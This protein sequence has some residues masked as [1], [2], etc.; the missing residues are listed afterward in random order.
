M[1][2]LTDIKIVLREKFPK[3]AARL[4]YNNA[5][6]EESDII[7]AT[8]WTT[9]Y[10]IAS[11]KTKARRY[12]YV[13]DFEP[14]FQPPGTNSVLADNTYKLGFRGITLGKWLTQK[15]SKEYNMKCDYFNFGFNP[16][17]YKIVNTSQR[18][19]VLFYARPRTPRRGFEL[20]VMALELFHKQY[21]D[22]KIHFFGEDVSGY[23]IPFPYVNHCV[24]NVEQLAHLYNECAAGLAISLSNVSLIPLEMIAAGCTPVMNDAQY[25]RLLAYEEYVVYAEP[26]PADL[27]N[28]LDA[29]IKGYSLESAKK[30]S[31]DIQ[32]YTWDQSNET[33]ESLL[34]RDFDDNASA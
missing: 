27:F 23:N 30:A 6:F 16:D 31:N 4:F 10:P 26:N 12:Y 2:N 1:T 14:Y 29:A 5:N 15:L 11:S 13:Q 33:I 34:I 19:S 28:S 3:I 25:T 32:S 7:F 24:I 20:G 8:H 9:A 22:Y 17:E 18:K 21:P